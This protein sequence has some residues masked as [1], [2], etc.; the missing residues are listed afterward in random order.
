M[1]RKRKQA[2]EI[3]FLDNRKETTP[4]LKIIVWN[5]TGMGR[6]Q[7]F[8]EFIADFNYVARNLD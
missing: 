5:I 3:K 6:L 2:T 1:E 4:G 8:K 7:D